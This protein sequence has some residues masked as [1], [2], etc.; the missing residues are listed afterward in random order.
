M[1]QE[2]WGEK[3]PNKN[4][5]TYE[6]SGNPDWELENLDKNPD[7]NS[8]HNLYSK[9]TNIITTDLDYIESETSESEALVVQINKHLKDITDKITEKNK[10]ITDKKNK[11]ET[12]MKEHRSIFNKNYVDYQKKI[13]EKSNTIM[14]SIKKQKNLSD[15]KS[16]VY[17]K[18]INNSLTDIM[19]NK[20]LSSNDIV[21][22]VKSIA[23][24]CIVAKIKDSISSTILE[25][26]DTVNNL[27]EN[28][29]NHPN[30][31][32]C[33]IKIILKKND[34][35]I[36]S[37]MLE[38]YKCDYDS[39]E[40]GSKLYKSKTLGEQHISSEELDNLFITQQKVLSERDKKIDNKIFKNKK[41]KKSYYDIEN[42]IKK[43]KNKDETI[44]QLLNTFKIINKN[45]MSTLNLFSKN[46]KK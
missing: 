40:G 23:N 12:N 45:N 17:L 46:I 30:I 3:I 37:D 11:L 32:K 5:I 6:G 18:C 10:K 44:D 26:P 29:T 22:E 13:E 19:K 35:A 42:V 38:K 41:L 39:I 20:S 7:M 31:T 1:S 9:A 36:Y 34:I 43:S 27:K 2:Q 28:F 4:Y 14:N 15:E 33:M 16:V 8:F 25:N 24:K 21:S